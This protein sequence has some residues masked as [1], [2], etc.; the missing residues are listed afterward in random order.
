MNCLLHIFCNP[1]LSNY[2]IT[3]LLVTCLGLSTGFSTAPTIASSRFAELTTR[4][5]RT[6]GWLIKSPAD[7]QPENTQN[8]QDTEFP[9]VSEDEA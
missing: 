5:S 8:T 9:S 3:Y 2:R 4:L 6:N 7:L 1:R